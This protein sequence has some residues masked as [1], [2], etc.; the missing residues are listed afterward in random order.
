MKKFFVS[1]IAV[2]TA[3]VSFAA[4]AAPQIWTGNDAVQ[5]CLTAAR[6]GQAGQPY[7]PTTTNRSSLAV[8]R[9]PS[10]GAC[11]E[12]AYIYADQGIM[13]SATVFVSEGFE[14]GEEWGQSRVGY[15]MIKCNNPFTGL[16]LVAQ[17]TP[18][19][20]PLPVQ[21]AAVAPESVLA[22]ACNASCLLAQKNAEAL[23][24]CNALG[25]SFTPAVALN[26]EGVCNVQTP[27]YTTNYSGSVHSTSTMTATNAPPVVQDNR[28]Q[29]AA[30]IIPPLSNRY[31]VQPSPPVVQGGCVN[32]LQPPRPQAQVPMRSQA[33]SGPCG[34][35]P[36]RPEQVGHLTKVEPSPDG[37]CRIA[38]T[39]N[40]KDVTHFVAFQAYDNGDLAAFQQ[41]WN[42]NAYVQVGQKMR[43]PGVRMTDCLEIIRTVS[44]GRTP[45][46]RSIWDIVRNGTGLPDVCQPMRNGVYS[47]ARQQPVRFQ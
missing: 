24:A 39:T 4:S 3:M 12:G 47:P 33:A 9:V 27:R 32:C 23:Q 36:C 5:K 46:G 20:S 21:T 18:V 11:L 8:K 22:V 38:A 41:Q 28:Q 16:H 35:I 26:G 31:L 40:N 44:E 34:P 45:Q 25:G 14:Y 13:T 1:V 29:Y 7:T 42:G 17:S 10:G 37:V 15:R 2:L 30:A 6:A 43:F 19:A